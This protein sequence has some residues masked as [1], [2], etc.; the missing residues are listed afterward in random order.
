MASHRLGRITEDIHREL[1]A[2]FREV[3]DPRVQEGLISIVRVDVTNDLSYCT[4]Y[5]SAMQGLEQAKVA[6]KGLK[7]AAGFIRR[8]LR[9]VPQL[10]F[11]ATDSI[12]Y[13]A[14]ISKLIN[15]LKEE[16]HHED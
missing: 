3:K 16:K 8:K 1:T 11:T 5:I 7:S 14:G 9:H 15:D 10:I 13:G 4:V 12:E 6:E 2:I